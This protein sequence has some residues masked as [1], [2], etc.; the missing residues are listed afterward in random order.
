VRREDLA[1]RRLGGRALAR[2]LSGLGH[3][4]GRFDLR[5]CA[6]LVQSPF[7]GPLAVTLREHFGWR[8]V[9]DCLDAHPEFPTNRARVLADA[10][11]RLAGSA[12]MVVATSEPLRR[13]ME[14]WNPAARLLPNACDFALFAD[15][16]APSPDAESLTIGYVG[17]VDSWFDM[18]L[19]ARVADLEP[20][21]R[22]EIVGAIED[23]A[24]RIP[25]RP[26]LT[27]HGER[28]HREMP[29][30]RRRFD[31]EIIPFR[32]S[33]LTHATDPVKLY[34]AA[35]AGRTVVATPMRSLEQFARR[36]LVRLASTPEDF[37]REIASAAREG[38]EG[39]RRQ[40][41]FARENTWDI[42]ALAL[43]TWLGELAAGP[44]K[45]AARE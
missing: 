35:A 40:R 25:R 38:G 33:A 34:E 2:A 17:A 16:P 37:A 29:D 36:G 28:A 21:W 45:E 42:R 19:L 43:A 24:S 11:R 7:W 9:Y 5:E 26:N 18:D 23:V 44:W 27:F 15:L 13:Q 30:F 3:A 1:E 6:L 41:A 32:L 10:E 22:F 4:R 39:A 8:I 31:V 14:R 12:D 20:R